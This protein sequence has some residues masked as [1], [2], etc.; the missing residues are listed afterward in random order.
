MC[1][2]SK[3]IYL[4]QLATIEARLAQLVREQGSASAAE[5]LA[6]LEQALGDFMGA[7][8]PWDDITLVAVKRL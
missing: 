1:D 2:H 5:L 4:P 3:N 8:T 7:T 6:A